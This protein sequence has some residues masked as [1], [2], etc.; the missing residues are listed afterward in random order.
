MNHDR[1]L[2][3]LTRGQRLRY[4]A[5]IASMGLGIVV[6][7][8]V[9]LYLQ[10]A[11]DR[12]ISYWFAGA[13]VVGLTALA[14]VFHYLRGRWAA[15]ASEAIV[16]RTRNRLYSHLEKLPC[17][18]HDKADTG[19]LVQRCTSDVETVRVFLSGQVAHGA[20]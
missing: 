12:E 3:E 5:A 15:I 4:A 17:S 14:G 11:L 7:F 10:R 1:T 13:W 8:Q 9:P 2:W 16:R 20:V 19:D 6:L 18:F